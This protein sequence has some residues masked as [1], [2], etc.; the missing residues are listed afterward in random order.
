MNRPNW[1]RAG[2]LMLAALL[3]TSCGGG[4]GAEG[5]DDST[6]VV[7]VPA[8]ADTLDWTMHAETT[9]E[10]ALWSINEALVETDSD[11]EL[12]PSLA[13][14]LPE[15]D[16]KDPERWRVTLKEGITFTNGEPFNAEAVKANVVRVAAEDFETPTDGFESYAGAEV[17]D[18]YVV[19]I[20]T[21]GPDSALL[22]KLESLRMLAPKAMNDPDYAEN[23]VGTGP[24]L[25]EKWDRGREIV[26]ERNPDYWGEAGT[27]ET[28]VIRF[29]EDENTRV[30]A[31]S[32]GEI[33]PDR[34]R[35]SRPGAASAST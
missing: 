23:P 28:V 9:A 8:D 3:V 14:S 16:P 31:L 29:I 15:P 4:S 12:V 34:A 35:P 32:T 18:E 26:L 5:G 33:D 21:D 24:Y 11:G 20:L 25:F 30:A 7:A 22:Y 13:A 10:I 17:V 19:D 1:A 27:V 2:V 6:L